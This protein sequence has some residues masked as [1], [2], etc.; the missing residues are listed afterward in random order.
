MDKFS[1]IVLLFIVIALMALSFLFTSLIFLGVTWAFG[2]TFSWK[3]SF[4]I[5]LVAMFVSGLFNNGGG[6]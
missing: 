6:K 3:V 1:G 5:W 2:W 4:G